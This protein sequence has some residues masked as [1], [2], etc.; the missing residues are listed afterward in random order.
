MSTKNKKNCYN[1]LN[2]KK[3]IELINFSE[4]NSIRTTANRFN[5]GIGTVVRIKQRKD[6]YLQMYEE[7]VNEGRL[8]KRKKN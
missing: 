2:L 6:E 7:N 3:K 4:S 5:V 1:E 8:R